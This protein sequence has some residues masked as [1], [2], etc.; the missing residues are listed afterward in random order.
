[1]QKLH[2][3]GI[4][5]RYRKSEFCHSLKHN[6]MKKIIKNVFLLMLLGVSNE[7]FCQESQSK[8]LTFDFEKM[9][10]I[11]LINKEYSKLKY[12]DNIKVKVINYNPILYNVV[13]TSDDSII[14]PT[15]ASSNMIHSLI[16]LDGIQGFVKDIIKIINKSIPID[17]NEA[18]NTSTQFSLYKHTKDKSVDTIEILNSLNTILIETNTY[19]R[20]VQNQV[21]RQIYSLKYEKNQ[22][23][24][25]TFTQ[26]L[27]IYTQQLLEFKTN[28]KIKTITTPIIDST[29]KLLQNNEMKNFIT[30]LY[31]MNLYRSEYTTAPL[32]FLEDYKKI[33]IQFQ[34]KLDTNLP[35]YSPCVLKLPFHNR[36]KFGISAGLYSSLGL[37][38]NQYS[39]TF[40]STDS[41]YQLLENK[42]S[43]FEI[44]VNALAYHGWHIGSNNYLGGTVGAGMSIE[45]SPKPRLFIGGMWLNGRSNSFSLS[46]G[47]VLGYVNKLSDNFTANEKYKTAEANHLKSVLNTGAFFSV[48]YSIF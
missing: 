8:M 32:Y 12:G 9:K 5:I 17:K 2:L 41:S 37:Y 21:N 1:M 7:I 42:G 47:L 4:D 31:R 29:I 15:I 24:P 26:K 34:R 22:I 35:I 28:S 39:Y 10:F 20:N 16:G 3:C 23:N 30:S 13:V 11:D 14:S 40:N 44:G 27:N 19:I 43:S 18:S 45:S 33:T 6:V 48:N 25:D 46:L 36:T 38:S